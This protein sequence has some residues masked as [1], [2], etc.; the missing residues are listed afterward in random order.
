MAC[1]LGDLLNFVNDFWSCIGLLVLC[2]VRIDRLTLKNELLLVSHLKILL[3]ESY[4]EFDI[5][6]GFSFVHI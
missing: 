3:L 2:F 6:R 1:I 5:D 4:R